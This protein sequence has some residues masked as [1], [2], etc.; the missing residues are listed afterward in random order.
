MELN[1]NFQSALDILGLLQGLTL[2]VLLIAMNFRHSRSTCLLG[3][4]LL[5]FS[6]KLLIFIPGGLGLD[7]KFPEWFLLPFDF[8]WLLFAVFF[9]YTQQIS[10]F[11]EQKTKYWLLYPGILS[12]MLQVYIYFQPYPAK[13]EIAQSYWYELVF[14][15]AGILYSWIIG[16]WN[17][18]LLEK[19]RIEVENTFSELENKLLTWI[20]IYLIYSIISSVFIHILY[21]IS[22]DNYYFKII[23]SILDLVAIYWV[24]IHGMKQQNVLSILGKRDSGTLINYK[25]GLMESMRSTRN[26]SQDLKELMEAIDSY[27]IKSEVFLNSELTI[28]DLADKL[29][30]HPKRI[31]ASINTV[32]KQ[33]FNT[34]I[35]ELRIK[36]A[37][38]IL[39]DTNTHNFSIEGIG[40]EVGFHSKSAFYAAFKKVTG[41]TP[42]KY[43]E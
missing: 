14:T 43:K 26:D 18:R 3:L 21:I 35:N 33:N 2:G 9:I 23:F 27:M 12:F 13:V 20:R 16:I 11:S 42:T 6:L 36:K 1:F 29:N 31:S 10:I 5:L 38:R 8:S 17:L 40:Q 39:N 41:T 7:E 32:S 30:I 22:P 24:A 28:V 19:H 37:K 34:Y 15:F 4:Y 25:A